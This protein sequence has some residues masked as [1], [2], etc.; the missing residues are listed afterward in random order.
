MADNVKAWACGAQG[1]CM[2]TGAPCLYARVS[3][4]MRRLAAFGLLIAP[5]GSPQLSP[6]RRPGERR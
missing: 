6:L 3:I 1:L 2:G 4:P 5:A